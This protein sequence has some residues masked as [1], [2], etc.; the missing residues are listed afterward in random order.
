MRLRGAKE[1]DADALA[2]L[3]QASIRELCAPAYQ[4]NE[5]LLA[6]WADA[7][8]PECVRELI[9]IE[10]FFIV[11]EEREK[12]QGFICGT[13][14]LSTFALFVAP[15][16]IRNGVGTRLFRCYENLAKACGKK[17][18]AFYSSLNAVPF[19]EKMGA[20]VCGDMI[21]RPRPCLPMRKELSGDESS[22]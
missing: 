4:Y 10:E 1:T 22:L 2:L 6:P 8:T 9:R 20:E 13:F 21:Y 3:W 17:V 19:Y 12:L 16:S 18:L 14:A 5:A 15:D 7:K 11:A